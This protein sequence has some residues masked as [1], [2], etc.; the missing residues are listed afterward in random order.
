MARRA[1]C[2]RCGKPEGQHPRPDGSCLYFVQ[3]A[4]VWLRTANSVPMPK[5]KGEQ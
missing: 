4:P 3:R 5:P 2:V 1:R